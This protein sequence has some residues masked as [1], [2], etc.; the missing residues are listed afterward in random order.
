MNVQNNT[1]SFCCSLISEVFH[2]YLLLNLLSLPFSQIASSFLSTEFCVVSFC[3]LSIFVRVFQV[4]GVPS[5]RY[6]P[7]ILYDELLLIVWFCQRIQP[8]IL[9]ESYQQSLDL[10][11]LS[12]LLSIVLLAFQA[13]L[14]FQTDTLQLCQNKFFMPNSDVILHSNVFWWFAFTESCLWYAVLLLKIW[15]VLPT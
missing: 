6:F 4:V 8:D 3:T 14:D 5:L 9:Q 2:P 7:G 10:T 11:M 15:Q 13:D 12:V 1:I